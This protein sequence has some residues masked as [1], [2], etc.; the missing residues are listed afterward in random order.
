MKLKLTRLLPVCLTAVGLYSPGTATAAVSYD[1]EAET[2]TM[3]NS[4]DW[5]EPAIRKVLHS[6]AYGGFASDRQIADWANRDP[7]QAI[8][9]M[10]NFD[11]VNN[12]LSPVE[13]AT[14]DH[15]ARLQTLQSFWSSDAPDN[16]QRYDER[17][18]YGT[19]NVGQ[20]LSIANL[21]RTWI[22]AIN[23]RGCN[24]FLHKAAFYLT[25]YQAAISAHKTK[26]ALMRDYYD[27][28][29]TSLNQG[30]NLTETL[31][32]AAATAAVARAYGHQ[33]NY[34]KRAALRY[35]W[36]LA[37]YDILQFIRWYAISTIFHNPSTYKY[38][39]AFD[40]NLTLQNSNLLS[41]EESYARR[42]RESARLP[43]QLQGAEVFEPVHDVFGGQ[44]GL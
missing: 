44:T 33:N 17:D 9:E 30:R 15:C 31:A 1:T 22:Q 25:N 8:Q 28:I 35:L 10:L 14:A 24:P 13:D 19:L 27:S 43:M 39:T 7:V 2:F 29:I 38:R 42:S 37:N 36:R 23:T 40:R 32:T 20:Q 26:A 12:R 41:N 21:Q 34:Y 5:D 4:A 16:P 3:V 18:L 6:F 11:I